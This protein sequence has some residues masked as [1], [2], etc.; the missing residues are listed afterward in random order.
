M[1]VKS[2]HYITKDVAI[3]IIIK[4]IFECNDSQL[5]DTLESI[6]DSPFHNFIIVDQ[7]DFEENKNRYEEWDGDIYFSRLPYIESANQL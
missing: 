3:Q 5:A 1:S 6:V 4:K 7:E 2:T